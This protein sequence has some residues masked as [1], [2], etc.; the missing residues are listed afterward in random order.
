[1]VVVTELHSSIWSGFGHNHDGTSSER[2]QQQSQR[3]LPRPYHQNHHQPVKKKRRMDG[4]SNG[5]GGEI[6]QF[7]G[8]QNLVLRKE[9]ITK[10][11]NFKPSKYPTSIYQIDRKT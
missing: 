8:D 7:G 9:R 11:F 5:L 2:Q 1:M 10:P 6:F 3:P 4:S